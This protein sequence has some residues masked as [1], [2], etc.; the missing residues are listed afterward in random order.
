VSALEESCLMQVTKADLELM[1][2]KQIK[3]GRDGLMRQDYEMLT[4]FFE[5]N[6]DL[7]SSWR[8]KMGV[9]DGRDMQKALAEEVDLEIGKH[10]RI[11]AFDWDEREQVPTIHF[12]K[13]DF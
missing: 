12:K 5:A 6:Y 2:S 11:K 3:V 4:A 13:S 10:G 9:P 1:L 8:S 7:K